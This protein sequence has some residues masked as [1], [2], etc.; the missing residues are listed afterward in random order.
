MSAS[1]RN[2]WPDDGMPEDVWRSSRHDSSGLCSNKFEIGLGKPDC[3][4]NKNAYQWLLTVFGSNAAGSI[5]VGCHGHGRLWVP[6]FFKG[7][8]ER[9]SFFAIVERAPS[10]ASAALDKTSLVHDM[11]QDVDGAIGLEG[12]SGLGGRQWAWRAER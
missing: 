11:S 4:S 12:L 2:E 10:S 7:N 9:A 3:G 8:A 6:H 1:T 5:I